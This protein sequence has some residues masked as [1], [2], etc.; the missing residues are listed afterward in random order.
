MLLLYK[1][2]LPQENPKTSEWMEIPQAKQWVINKA[3]KHPI[4][5]LWL[6]GVILIGL[7]FAEKLTPAIGLLG[8]IIGSI[9]H[10][11]V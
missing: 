3:I 1:K 9:M 8:T 5:W 7:F 6:T 10:M 11:F 4:T 2:I